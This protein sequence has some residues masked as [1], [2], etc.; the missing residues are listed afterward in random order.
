M[1]E[2]PGAYPE[3]RRT[4]MEFMRDEGG[5]GEYFSVNGYNLRD[6]LRAGFFDRREHYA[7]LLGP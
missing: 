4:R 7:K 1:V 5:G 2:V 3:M 6:G